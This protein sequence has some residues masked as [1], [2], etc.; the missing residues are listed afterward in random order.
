VAAGLSGLGVPYV[1]PIGMW[2]LAAASAFTFWQRVHAAWRSAAQLAAEDATA[3]A[4][5]AQA[6]DDE[7]GSEAASS[8]TPTYHSASQTTSVAE[9]QDARP[10]A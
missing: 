3:P 9:H 10:G 5:T 4:G 2:L 7:A 6:A 8:D 1:L